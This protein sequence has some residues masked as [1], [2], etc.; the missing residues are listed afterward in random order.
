MVVLSCWVVWSLV[1]LAFENWKL[2]RTSK[3]WN[4][5]YFI[6][7]VTFLFAIRI[8]VVVSVQID[9]VAGWILS[10]VLIVVRCLTFL[11]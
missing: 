1:V 5:R 11:L 7:R 8:L 10:I 6:T 9:C 4:P 3:H 2:W